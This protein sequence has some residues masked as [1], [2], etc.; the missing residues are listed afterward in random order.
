MREHG[1]IVAQNRKYVF[2]IQKFKVIIVIC[3]HNGN[4]LS[5]RDVCA[6]ARL[7]IVLQHR[8]FIMLA[9]I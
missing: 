6:R 9:F 1:V 4:F 7:Y 8:Y 2:R 3:A 5:N